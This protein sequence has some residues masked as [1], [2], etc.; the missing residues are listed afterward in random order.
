MDL[1]KAYLA[2]ADRLRQEL[3]RLAWREKA[4]R[5]LAFRVELLPWI[6]QQ[7]RKCPD[8]EKLAT[9]TT[10]WPLL[11]QEAVSYFLSRGKKEAVG[12]AVHVL[13]R[14]WEMLQTRTI[15]L[16]TTIEGPGG[17]PP[18]LPEAWEIERQPS[19]WFP[20]FWER[21]EVTDATM[22]RTSEWCEF[23]AFEPWWTRL[24]KA[25]ETAFFEQ[26]AGLTTDAGSLWLFAMCRSH[27]AVQ[28]MR[29]LL[30]AGLLCFR[31]RFEKEENILLSTA[32]VFAAAQL[33]T[34]DDIVP[35]PLIRTAAADLLRRATDWWLPAAEQ[36]PNTESEVVATALCLHALAVTQPDGWRLAAEAG[37]RWLKEQQDQEDGLW[38]PGEW[39]AVL[40]GRTLSSVWTTVLVLDAL[41]LVN[42]VPGVTFRFD[43]LVRDRRRTYSLQVKRGEN[44]WHAKHGNDLYDLDPDQATFLT[45]LIEAQGAPVRGKDIDVSRPDRVK[46]SLPRKLKELVKSDPGKGYWIPLAK[47]LA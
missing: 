11:N 37:C 13:Q 7:A 12:D 23:G 47:I 45:R 24:K 31:Y 21:D 18:T 36:S 2:R 29:F 22:L 17:R 20:D 14:V 30:T 44:T 1:E 39:R 35:A 40:L 38:R 9:L 16:W 46:K 5:A 3:K 33:G 43:R 42:D 34:G 8:Q 25:E 6:W 15:Q 19:P 41:D 4:E 32:L 10:I 27:K 26:A 28:L